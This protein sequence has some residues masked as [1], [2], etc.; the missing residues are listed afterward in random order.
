MQLIALLISSASVSSTSTFRPFPRYLIVIAVPQLNIHNFG[1]DQYRNLNEEE[2]ILG[3][4]IVE[5]K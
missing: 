4:D 3:D 2:S 5:L 1:N